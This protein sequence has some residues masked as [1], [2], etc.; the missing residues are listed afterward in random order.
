MR[1]PRPLGRCAGSPSVHRERRACAV[2]GSAASASP[3]SVSVCGGCRAPALG[4][5]AA[6]LPRDARAPGRSRR[7][8]R[9]LATVAGPSHREARA[10]GGDAARRLPRRSADATPRPPRPARAPPPGA[11]RSPPRAASRPRPRRDEGRVVQERAV[12][13]QDGDLPAALVDRRQST[14]RIGRRQLDRPARLVHVAVLFAKP[15]ADDERRIAERPREPVAQRAG[16]RRLTQVD[17]EPG[18]RRPVPTPPR[19]DPRT[20]R[21]RSGRRP[22][23]VDDEQACGRPPA[24]GSPRPP[25]R[26]RARTGPPLR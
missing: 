3:W 23:V 9:P 26:A 8:A 21:S 6:P 24:L 5:R 2:D 10:R 15:V 16:S 20:G 11:G 22:K 25:R 18:H 17:H 1:L 7:R 12:V 4:A 13:D 14:L 19:A